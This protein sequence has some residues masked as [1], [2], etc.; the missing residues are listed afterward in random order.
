M[1]DLWA[2]NI[3]YM[4]LHQRQQVQTIDLYL[5]FCFSLMPIGAVVYSKLVCPQAERNTM[6]MLHAQHLC[7]I[8]YILL[9]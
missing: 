1:Y 7:I 9:P 3:R 6:T 2:L 4:K 8:G 5:Y